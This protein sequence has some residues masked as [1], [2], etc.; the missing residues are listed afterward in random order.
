MDVC[1]WVSVSVCVGCV[2]VCV[3]V[4]MCGCPRPF[5]LVYY[6]GDDCLQANSTFNEKH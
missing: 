2:W 5:I 6:A 1:V 3:S 4:C